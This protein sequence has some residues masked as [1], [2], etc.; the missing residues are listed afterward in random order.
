MDDWTDCATTTDRETALAGIPDTLAQ[1]EYMAERIAREGAR[2]RGLAGRLQQAMAAISG[3]RLPDGARPWTIIEVTI[4]P[5]ELDA[6][7]A[8]IRRMQGQFPGE[9]EDD[10]VNN[11]FSVAIAHAMALSDADLRATLDRAPDAIRIAS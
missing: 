6:L 2:A 9:T 5:R 3:R 7:D 4:S 8:L 10:C 11:L 1:L